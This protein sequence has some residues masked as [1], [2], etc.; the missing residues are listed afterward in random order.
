MKNICPGPYLSKGEEE[1]LWERAGQ[2]AASKKTF[3]ENLVKSGG[4]CA[5]PVIFISPLRASKNTIKN[6]F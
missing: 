1:G 2:K 5:L 3:K 4:F 6:K